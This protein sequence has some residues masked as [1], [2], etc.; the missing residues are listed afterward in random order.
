M[1]VLLIIL[2]ISVP[3]CQDKGQKAYS[4]GNYDEA[5]TYY[6]Y[7]LKN[8]DH[9]L[10]A[11]FGLGTTAYKQKDTES[12]INNLK[13]TID[14]DDNNLASKAFYNLASIYSDFQKK[15]HLLKKSLEQF[16]TNLSHQKNHHLLT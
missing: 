5:R 6:E 11:N 2:I 15:I 10:S 7:I 1:K 8:R 16:Q 12:A 3:F 9:D 13:K 4:N 14:S